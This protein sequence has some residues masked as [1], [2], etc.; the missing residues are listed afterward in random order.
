MPG[1]EE[2]DQYA[3][4]KPLRPEHIPK[5]DFAEFLSNDERVRTQVIGKVRTAC[6][7]TGFFYLHN[8]GVSDETINTALDAIKRFFDSNDDG[9]VKQAVHNQATA[10]KRGWGPMFSEPAYQNNT[11]AHL[12]SFDIGQ[13]LSDQE[14]RSTGIHPNIWPGQ[15]GFRQALTDYYDAVTTVGRS[16]AEVFSEIL[17]KDREFINR[18]SGKSAPRTMRLL[19]YPANG[20][21]IND[22]HVG[23]AAHTDF[24]CFTLMNQTAEGLELTHIDGDWCQAPADIGTFTIILGDMMERF[25]NGYFKATGHR[26]VNTPWT[27][28]SM[29]LFYALDGDYQVQP[30]P[31]FTSE[32]SPPRFNP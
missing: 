22:R 18:H 14:H 9:P 21:Q 3:P 20:T 29:V 25:S 17:G 5:L 13:Q 12:E 11:V 10:G 4:S 15:A 28:Y 2:L 31:G 8:C 30:L 1:T 26:V 6:L 7:H 27:R 19:H 23:I 24:E 32:N 16:L